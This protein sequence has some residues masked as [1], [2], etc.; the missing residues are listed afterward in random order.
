[1]MDAVGKGKNFPVSFVIWLSVQYKKLLITQLYLKFIS[2]NFNT[3]IKKRSEVGNIFR[4]IK[5]TE[6]IKPFLVMSS[7]TKI[8]KGKKSKDFN[9]VSSGKEAQSETAVT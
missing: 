3:L 4:L 5:F 6:S 1:M 2:H 8:K 7:I 9:F